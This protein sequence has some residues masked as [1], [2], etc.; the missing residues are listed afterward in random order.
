MAAVGSPA[1][2]PLQRPGPIDPYRVGPGTLTGRYLRLFWQPVS[3]ASDLPVSKARP[4]RVMGEDFTVYRGEGGEPHLVDFRCAH[5][6]TQLS[7]GWVEGDTIR[8]RYHGW[9]YDPT[10]QCV[11]QPAE[12]EPFCQKVSI[13]AYPTLE[14]L[15]LIFAYLG[16]GDPPPRPRFALG[17]EDGVV[18]VLSYVRRCRNPLLPAIWSV[19]SV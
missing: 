9:A 14:Y 3:I 16:E 8:C 7:I 6:R 1:S 12:P 5:R 13:R 11:E 4:V 18:E 17:E 15:G 2:P 19:V 10:G